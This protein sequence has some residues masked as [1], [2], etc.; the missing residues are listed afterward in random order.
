MGLRHTVSQILMFLVR[1]KQSLLEGIIDAYKP[2]ADSM[3]IQLKQATNDADM[4]W[5]ILQERYELEG[6]ALWLMQTHPVD[7]WVFYGE[8][9][10][11]TLRMKDVLNKRLAD[12]L[13]RYQIWCLDADTRKESRLVLLRPH[14]DPLY[15]WLS[16][17]QPVHRLL[18]R[19]IFQCIALPWQLDALER[20]R[21]QQ[22]P[23]VRV[24]LKQLGCLRKDQLTALVDTYIG[25]EALNADVLQQRAL[26]LAFQA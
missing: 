10:Q 12:W 11:H 18:C 6:L 24:Y 20:A 17:Q 3:S 25:A 13:D 1:R 15:G 7:R 16:K 8:H 2:G 23:A 14:H 4:R 19:Y 22:A 26:R 5:S 21:L 9:S